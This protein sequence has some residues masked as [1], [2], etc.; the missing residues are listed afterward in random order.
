MLV[1]QVFLSGCFILCKIEHTPF[2]VKYKNRTNVLANQK[3][4]CYH[5]KQNKRSAKAFQE[6]ARQDDIL[7][8]FR[9]VFIYRDKGVAG[10]GRGNSGADI[11]I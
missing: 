2:A 5:N 10:D 1:N 4:L 3:Q 7:Y 8:G 11:F 6:E 9:C